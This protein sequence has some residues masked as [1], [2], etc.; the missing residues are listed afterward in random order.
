MIA[1]RDKRFET[2]D[3][4]KEL[5]HQMVGQPDHFEATMT[6]AFL[7][8]LAAIDFGELEINLPKA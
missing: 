3:A 2:L 6:F 5:L 1:S 4:T 8:S 7:A